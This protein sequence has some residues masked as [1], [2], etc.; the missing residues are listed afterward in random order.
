M[1]KVVS[2]N[3]NAQHEPWR[4]LVQM[5]ADV[6]LLQEACEPPKDVADKV[7]IGPREHWDSHHWN[8]C[9]W[10]GRF[11]N[12][13]DRWAMVVKLSNKVEVEWFKQISP[14]S[15]AATDEFPVSGIGT[16]AA[17][18]IIPPDSPP[19]IV[20][21]MYAR[22][23]EPHP[24]AKRAFKV[25]FAD[26][27][28]HRIISDLS[29]FIGSADA[30][31]H[32]IL[33]AGDLNTIYGAKDY[34]S[35]SWNTARDHT[36]WDRMGVIGL[37]FLGPRYPNG[38]QADPTPDFMKPDNRD[39]VTYYTPGNCPA[40]ADRQLDYAFASRGFHKTIKVCAMNGVKKWGSSDHCRLMIEVT[41][42]EDRFKLDKAA[43]SRFTD[44]I[45][46]LISR[47]AQGEI[48][49]PTDPEE[50]QRALRIERAWAVYYTNG[51]ESLLVEEGLFPKPSEDD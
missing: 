10:R 16:V 13:F 26:G 4:E 15:A 2:W 43:L 8:S 6:A 12:L 49:Y 22:W 40:T 29:G 11:K 42:K 23:I 46:I 36:I 27:S 5:D 14:I 17:A 51:D 34:H 28:A 44:P 30:S 33:A 20:V 25:G 21:S 18:R 24:S 37:E 7:C 50:I 19:F 35:T 1:T 3:I 9:W 38:K 45:G 32:R 41:G 47:N 31:T 39:V 48:T